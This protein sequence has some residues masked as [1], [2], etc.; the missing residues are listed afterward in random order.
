MGRLAS[1]IVFWI[2]SVA[3]LVAMATDFAGVIARALGM[4]PLGLVEVVQFCV[5]GA[6]SSAL[7]IATVGGA[8]AA[9][10]VL[11]E[12][13]PKSAARFLL[14]LS[15][16]LGFGLFAVFAFG[17]A[18][19]LSDTFSL[20]ERTDVIGLPVA[21]ARMVWI[22]ALVIVAVV[23]LVRAFSK[24]APEAPPEAAALEEAREPIDG[25]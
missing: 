12:R 19:M 23:F 7:I 6:I 17:C 22:A 10:H 20:N 13:L 8:H 21:P 9:V 24:T 5:V 25:A 11:T 4:S 2:G 16:L 14:R 3:L 18:W 1:T 15:D